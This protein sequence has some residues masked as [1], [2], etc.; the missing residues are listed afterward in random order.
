MIAL[1]AMWLPINV[2]QAATSSIKLSNHQIINVQAICASSVNVPQAHSPSVSLTTVLTYFPFSSC[3]K[4]QESDH[5]LT[6]PVPDRAP[7][8]APSTGPSTAAA[9]S[10][11]PRPA[12]AQGG[13]RLAKRR[14]RASPAPEA[15]R[16]SGHLTV[17]VIG[18][19]NS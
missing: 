17:L 13:R 5:E 2:H 3:V 12:R 1:L 16:S 18:M 4:V 11:R 14:R 15:S 7:S 6:I 19:F 9:A 8:R 10:P